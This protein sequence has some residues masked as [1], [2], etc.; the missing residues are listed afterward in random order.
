MLERSFKNEVRSKILSELH[1]P[2]SKILSDLAYKFP[3]RKTA[4][5]KTTIFSFL[6]IINNLGF[7]FI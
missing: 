6:I 5:N 2:F 7:N 1:S 4:I 3:T